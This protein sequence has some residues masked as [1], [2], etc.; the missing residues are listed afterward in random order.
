M[1]SVLLGAGASM[2]AG[3]PDSNQLAGKLKHELLSS[4]YE[5]RPA[6]IADYNNN[7]LYLRLC[8][9]IE[10]G[11]R[12]QRG[13]LGYDPGGSINIEDITGAAIDLRRRAQASASSFAVGWHPTLLDLEAQNPNLL[14]DFSDYILS[15]IPSWLS[16]ESTQSVEYLSNLRE[17]V[18]SERVLD[19][20]SLNYDLC[21][22]EA[23]N[24]RGVGQWTNG[25]DDKGWNPALFDDLRAGVRLF[26]LHGSLDWIYDPQFGVCSRRYPV[27][28]AADELDFTADPLLIF[29]TTEKLSGRQPFITLAYHFSE[30]L[31]RSKVIV[32]IGYSFGDPYINKMIEQAFTLDQEM[33]LIVVSPEARGIKEANAFL[34][35]SPRVACMER[36]A[37]SALVEG[38][39]N[40]IVQEMI[41][42]V[43]SAGP[44]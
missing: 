8:R 17:L 25:F 24:L 4:T 9:F 37:K 13:W 19:V 2:D 33:E 20:F 41:E 34:R 40:R 15:R 30:A 29:G 26:K 6:S 3:L 18:N 44:F 22:E 23:L 39:L 11:L 38:S 10:G 42:K 12:F 1:V 35:D 7:E 21:V 32:A 43:E 16:T 36:G 14:Q 28:Y 5:E 27:H 31:S